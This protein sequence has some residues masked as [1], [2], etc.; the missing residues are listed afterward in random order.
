MMLNVL[1]E[2][3]RIAY[4]LIEFVLKYV[5]SPTF[6]FKSLFLGETRTNSR[7]PRHLAIL[8]TEE[9]SICLEALCDLLV[10]SARS[11]VKQVSVYDPWSY[12][13]MSRKEIMRRTSTLLRATKKKC[14]PSIHFSRPGEREDLLRK[15]SSVLT[16]NLL[17]NDS[18]KQAI[19]RVC[20]KVTS[21]LIDCFVSKDFQLQFKVV[22]VD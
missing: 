13:Q 2:C 8:Y 16:V 19:V 9:S 6:M 17:G 12:V 15:P 1:L 7:P 14:V 5:S 11:G 3:V 18:G 22:F 20:K 4:A 21:Y 10:E